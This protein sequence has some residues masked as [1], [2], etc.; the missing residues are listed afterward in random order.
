[1]RR[2]LGVTDAPTRAAVASTHSDD[3]GWLDIPSPGGSREVDRGARRRWQSAQRGGGTGA[4]R[5]G[6]AGPVREHAR[7][8][9]RS[10]AAA[11]SCVTSLAPIVHEIRLGFEE[12]RKQ[13]SEAR[14]LVR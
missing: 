1:M 6:A 14:G 12:S 3:I 10:S 2:R 9:A 8:P 4:P 5:A 7:L 13:S 11:P